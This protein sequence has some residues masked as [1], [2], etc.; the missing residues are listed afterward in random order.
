MVTLSVV[1]PQAIGSFLR[2]RIGDHSGEFLVISFGGFYRHSMF[3]NC[4]DFSVS[5]SGLGACFLV[6]SDRS[7]VCLILFV[8]RS[9]YL[10]FFLYVSFCFIVVC[11]HGFYWDLRVYTWVFCTQ[12]R[13]PWVFPFRGRLSVAGWF[14]MIAKSPWMLLEYG[15]TSVSDQRRIFRLNFLRMFLSLHFLFFVL[16]LVH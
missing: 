7:K 14:L 9:F 15:Y 2:N 12:S 13:M 8:L 11:T 1:V 5:E 16:G 4:S 10:F 3:L 6:V